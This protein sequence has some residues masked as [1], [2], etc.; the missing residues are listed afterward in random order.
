MTTI[1]DRGRLMMKK[2]KS[3]SRVV[4]IDRTLRKLI[5]RNKNGPEEYNVR[6]TANAKR[7]DFYGD[8][9]N[10]STTTIW[11]PAHTPKLYPKPME[12]EFVF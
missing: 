11:S 9:V 2:E 10:R 8:T 5:R 4:R 6:S 7:A 1:R 3:S 12:T